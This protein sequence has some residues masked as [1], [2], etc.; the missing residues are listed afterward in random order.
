MSLDENLRRQ[1]RRASLDP[2]N[3]HAK[4]RALVDQQRAGQTPGQR[5]CDYLIKEYQDELVSLAYK[6]L[7][8]HFVENLK[9]EWAIRNCAIKWINREFEVGHK[10][11]PPYA[12]LSWDK[13]KRTLEL[14]LIGGIVSGHFRYQITVGRTMWATTSS[15]IDKII[16]TTDSAATSG[17]YKIVVGDTAA[18]G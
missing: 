4:T 17:V 10:A 16:I 14:C 11:A 13:E 9:L 5:L 8:L 3:P 18:T 2:E 6:C 12:D 15:A 7:K 1:D